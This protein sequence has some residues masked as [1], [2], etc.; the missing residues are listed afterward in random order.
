MAISCFEPDVQLAV[1]AFQRELL[2]KLL[3]EPRV[4]VELVSQRLKVLSCRV[5]LKDLRLV[6]MDQ[7][8]ELLNAHKDLRDELSN[9][10]FLPAKHGLI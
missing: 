9:L 7:R 4:L 2:H 8:A 3:E 5:A 1:V 10:G 6:F